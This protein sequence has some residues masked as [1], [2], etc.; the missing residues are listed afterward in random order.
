[1]SDPDLSQI[2]ADL[3]AGT[4]DAAEAARRIEAARAANSSPETPET[5]ETAE[6]IDEPSGPTGVKGTERVTIRAVGRR[7]T[8]IGDHTVATAS[9]TGEH[10]LRRQGDVLEVSADGEVGPKLEGFSVLNPPKSLD[11]LRGL[12]FARGLTIRVNPAIEVDVELTAGSLAVTNVPFLGRVR[13]TAGG[14][15]IKGVRRLTDALIQAGSGSIEGPINAGRSRVKIESGA[16]T[17]ALAPRASV[18]VRSSAQL[19]RVQWPDDGGA[20]D[21]VVFGNGTARLDL[22]VVMGSATV[23]RVDA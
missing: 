15:D 11:D 16:L 4:I 13:V 9:V 1:M 10:V 5:P 19:G 23:K 14:A 20:P 2:L 8:V 12:T 18:T 7:V 21:E 3:A 22:E 6:P 17:L